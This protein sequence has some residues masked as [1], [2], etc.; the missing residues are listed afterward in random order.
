[1]QA[2]IIYKIIYNITHEHFK[3]LETD[4]S[5]MIISAININTMEAY[6]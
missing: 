3:F 4:P 6:V 1:M 2:S 5:A